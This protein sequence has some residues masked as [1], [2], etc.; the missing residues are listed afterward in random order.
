VNILNVNTQIDENLKDYQNGDKNV[1]S[2]VSIARSYKNGRE[3]ISSYYGD[4]PLPVTYGPNYARGKRKEKLPTND[5]IRVQK[6]ADTKPKGTGGKEAYVMLM[7]KNEDKMMNLSKNAKL[8]L[9]SIFFGGIQWNT[10]KLVQTRS[11]KLH[12]SATIA[13]LIGS[14]E[15]TTLKALKEL[16]DKDI[17]KYDRKRKVYFMGA[18]IARKGAVIDD[19]DKI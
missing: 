4:I 16:S 12:T 18:D 2:P 8:I 17:V 15:R 9:F 3:F 14:S 13:K 5:E 7:T 10:D 11:K 19:E 1:L 6:K